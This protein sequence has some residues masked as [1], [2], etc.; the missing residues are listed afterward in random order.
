[1]PPKLSR[2]EADLLLRLEVLAGQPET[3]A[4]FEWFQRN[5]PGTDKRPAPPIPL[6]APEYPYFQRLV[7]FGEAV[8]L[9]VRQGHLSE[10]VARDRWMLEGP[11]SWLRLTTEQ[12]RARFG[13]RFAANFEWIATRGED[14]SRRR[15]RGAGRRG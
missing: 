12:E 1:M 7:G 11:W 6:S 10:E 14:G 13:P 3:R 5:Y 8:G 15:R 2:E 4:A 9:L